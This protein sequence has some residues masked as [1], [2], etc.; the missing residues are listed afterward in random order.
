MET[1]R[2]FIIVYTLNYD[3][4][5]FELIHWHGAKLATTTVTKKS[6]LKRHMTQTL[7]VCY[8]NGFK[9]NCVYCSLECGWWSLSYE[10]DRIVR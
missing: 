6:W 10:V 5:A 2:H 7:Y 9:V 1:R 4:K 8:D 3:V